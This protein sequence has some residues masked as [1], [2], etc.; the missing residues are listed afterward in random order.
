[1]G[2]IFN[3]AGLIVT[4]EIP[5]IVVF[6]FNNLIYQRREVNLL[7]CGGYATNNTPNIRLA[8]TYFQIFKEQFRVI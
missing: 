3:S 8:K 6:L 7:N 2:C 5:C 1:V 4:C